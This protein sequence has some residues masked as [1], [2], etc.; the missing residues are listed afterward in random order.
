MTKIEFTPQ[1]QAG[2]RRARGANLRRNI[3]SPGVVNRIRL[4]SAARNALQLQ[5]GGAVG[6]LA[7]MKGR[8]A[9]V[10]KCMAKD[11]GLIT[12]SLVKIAVDIALLDR[13]EGGEVAEPSEPGRGGSSAM[14]HKCRA[15]ASMVAIAE[16]RAPRRV[17]ALLGVMPQQH[18]RALGAWQVELAEWPQLLMSV[19]GSLCANIDRPRAELPR[20]AADE[21]FDPALAIN[22]SQTAHVWSWHCKPNSQTRNSLNDRPRNAE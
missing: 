1:L 3:G 18:E 7:H 11:L 22:V 9:V 10:H 2:G 14:P 15:V 17:A 13:Y 8:D 12:A 20:D 6:T 4:H 16:H 21:W 19:H 5:L